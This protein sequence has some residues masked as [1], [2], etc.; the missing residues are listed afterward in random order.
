MG[1]VR[2]L[3]ESGEPFED[4][5]EAGCM[6][7]GVLGEYRGANTVV[8]G[9]PR[10]GMVVAREL[11]RR[12]GAQTDLVL[13]RK[14]G[15]PGNPELAIGSV[16]EDG[17]VFVH[18][19]AVALTAASREYIQMEAR[20]VQAEIARRAG[21]YRQVCARIGIE[22]RIVLLTDDGVA[23]G[24][25]ME[26]AAWAVR[27]DNPAKVVIALPVAPQDTL[28]RLAEGVDEVV[29]LRCPPCFQSVGQF[30]NL[31]EQVEDE[32]LLAL[33]EACARERSP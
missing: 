3:S 31:F 16:S 14:L 30:Y 18:D 19:E 8:L 7:A 33:L 4:R 32:V 10:G 12:L 13:A 21:R 2:V 23:T 5:V 26:A 22:G 27:R 29:C 28:R 20:R 15:A 25:T 6:L 1:S 24:S 9:V 17:K 11:A